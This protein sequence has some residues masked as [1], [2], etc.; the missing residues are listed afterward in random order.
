MDEL[1]SVITPSFNTARFIGAAI[2]SVIAQTY[3]NWEMIIVDDHSSDGSIEIIEKYSSKD[4]R[5]K[6]IRLDKN[7]G[8]AIARNKAIQESKGRFIAFLDSDDLWKRN[9]LERQISYMIQHNASFTFSAYQRIDELGNPIG[10]VIEVPERVTYNDLLKSCVVGCLTAVYD[11]KKIGKVY[12]PVIRKAQDYALW[13]KILKMG[14]IGYGIQENL[15]YYRIRPHSISRN[16]MVKAFYQ[17]HIYRKVE[18]LSFH[19]SLYYMGHY[20]YYGLKKMKK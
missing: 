17:W 6:L 20:G 8:P 4:S 15:A 9:K 11:S 2:E 13:L 12:M 3:T 7:H 10:D 16:K 19:K 1:V 18:K 14:E 5:I